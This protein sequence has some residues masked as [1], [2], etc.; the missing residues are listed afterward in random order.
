MQD[1][2]LTNHD[3][4]LACHDVETFFERANGEKRDI[5]RTRLAVEEILLKYQEAF[6]T[7]GTF[8]FQCRKRM[9]RLH[10]GFSIPGERNDVVHTDS[11]EE[12]AVMK[13]ILSGMGE[14]PAW[15]FKNGVNYLTF[16]L[17][18]RK[19]SPAI[20]LLAAVALALFCGIVSSFLPEKYVDFLSEEMITPVFD[21]FMGL[22][23]AVAGPLIFL[24]VAGG[25]YNIGDIATLGKVG[26]RMISRFLWMTLIFTTV[27]G[28]AIL[29]LFPLAGSGS[30]S[31]Q[32]SELLD[33]VLGIV[34]DNFF[35]PFLEGNPLQIIFLA[36][37]AGLAMLI[38]GN[39]AAAVSSFLDQAN[40]IVLLIMENISAFVPIF[41]FG[42]LFNMILGK[43]FSVLLKAYKVLPVMLLGDVFLMAVYTGLVC[44]RKKVSVAV[45]LKKVFPVFLIGLTTASSTAAFLENRKV[46]E[47]KL[48]INKKIVNIGVPLGQVVFMP[49]FSILY[50]AMG[51]CMAEIYGVKISPVWL[52]TA[53]IIAVVLAVATPPIPGGALACYTILLL[54]LEIPAQ[55]IVIAVAINVILDFFATAVDL[56]CLEAELTE[57]AGDLEMLDVEKIRKTF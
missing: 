38:L 21:T 17:K 36:A 25:I 48:G 11:G 54:Q 53:L 26:K 43:N 29:P 28:V 46:C 4:D 27:F 47:E 9:N 6:G 41:I 24:S 57:L 34:P 55:A 7:K 13:G 22:L 42:S 51:I 40:A 1:Y 20:S 49:G 12:S 50:F 30:S 39:R 10:A 15:Q 32:L 16:T 2:T 5:I 44:I 3:I 8:Q 45:F 18:K 14:I 56:F 37:L 52:I 31:F 23:S 33:M 35:T 19:L